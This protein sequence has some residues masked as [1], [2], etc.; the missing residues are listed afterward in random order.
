[1]AQLS[2]QILKIKL[3]L[4]KTVYKTTRPKQKSK[5]TIKKHTKVIESQFLHLN[6]KNSWKSQ[7]FILNKLQLKNHVSIVCLLFTR[8]HKNSKN[9]EQ[10]RVQLTWKSKSFSDKKNK[11]WLIF[12]VIYDREIRYKLRIKN[13]IKFFVCHFRCGWKRNILQFIWNSVFANG[14][15]FLE[16]NGMKIDWLVSSL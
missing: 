2:T 8:N 1:M 11:F 14:F 7:V 5:K 6:L 9:L 13:H 12:R 15:R 4:R 3:K 16:R 10:G